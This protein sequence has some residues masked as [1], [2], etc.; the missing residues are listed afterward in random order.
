MFNELS[1][2]DIKI[3]FLIHPKAVKILMRT[4]KYIITDSGGIQPEAFFLKKRC[5]LIRKET[6]WT[7]YI[8]NNN[9]TLYY[10][11]EPLHL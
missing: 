7:D 1:Q 9:N 3:L 8:N 11:K 10:F 5:I 2:L 4:C 6:G